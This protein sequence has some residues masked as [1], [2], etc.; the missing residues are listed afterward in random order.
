MSIGDISVF[1]T[2]LEVA[3]T[4]TSLQMLEQKKQGLQTVE[5]Q[6]LVSSR[7][8]S[9]NPKLAHNKSRRKATH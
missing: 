6:D 8:L 9:T 4:Q 7:A 2:T 5:S 1:M 3:P